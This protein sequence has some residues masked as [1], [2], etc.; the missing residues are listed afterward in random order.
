LTI[1]FQDGCA[2][3]ALDVLPVIFD[4][5]EGALAFVALEDLDA[6]AGGGGEDNSEDMTARRKIRLKS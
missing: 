3:A 2:G 1:S 5:L 6:L 4:L